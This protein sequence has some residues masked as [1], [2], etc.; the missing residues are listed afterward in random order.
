MEADAA[1]EAALLAVHD[2]FCSGFAERDPDRVGRWFPPDGD[3]VMVTSED[4]LLRGT[5][6][7]RAFL[8]RYARGRTTYSWS[9]ERRDASA[10]GTV[11]WLLAQG[12]ETAASELGHQSHPYRMTLVCERRDGRWWLLQV[13]GSSPHQG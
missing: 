6:E 8:E 3:V 4:A 10:A 1:T 7:I 5:A 9:W 12:V 13:H 11:A 2:A